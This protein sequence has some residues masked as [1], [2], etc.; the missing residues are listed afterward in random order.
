MLLVH[1]AHGSASLRHLCLVMG[2]ASHSKFVGRVPLG[3]VLGQFS[4]RKAI[5]Q[6]SLSLKVV[7]GPAQNMAKIEMCCNGQKSGQTCSTK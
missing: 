5:L 4:D 3:Q 2:C 1:G 6:W 7:Q